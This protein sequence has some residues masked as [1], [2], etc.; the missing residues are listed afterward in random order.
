[1][2]C[3]HD[4]TPLPAP[5]SDFWTEVNRERQD[6]GEAPTGPGAWKSVA[7]SCGNGPCETIGEARVAAVLSP[8]KMIGRNSVG[9]VTVVVPGLTQDECDRLRGQVA[10]QYPA[11]SADGI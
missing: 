7:M 6:R 11:P 5:G 3:E 10:P 8:F 1:G 2:H 9:V 4:T